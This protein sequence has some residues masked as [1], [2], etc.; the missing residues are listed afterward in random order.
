MPGGFSFPCVHTQPLPNPT[1][2]HS[3]LSLLEATHGRH[4]A[5]VADQLYTL[6]HNLLAQGQGKA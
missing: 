6:A 4:S 5:L 1:H 2:H 3:L